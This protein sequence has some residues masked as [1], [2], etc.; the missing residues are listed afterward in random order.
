MLQIVLEITLI[1]I[2][3]KSKNNCLSIF[4][5][6]SKSDRLLNEFLLIKIFNIEGNLEKILILEMMKILNNKNSINKRS[7]LDFQRFINNF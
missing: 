1:Y 5:N 4:E 2:K 6:Q 3:I 7:D